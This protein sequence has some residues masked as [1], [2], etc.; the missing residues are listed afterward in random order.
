MSDVRPRDREWV[1]DDQGVAH[2][3][4]ESEGDCHSTVCGRFLRGTS[5]ILLPSSW[6]VP[7]CSACLNRMDRRVI[8]NRYSAVPRA[9][10]MGR[11]V[12]AE[13]GRHRKGRRRGGEH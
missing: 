2:M 9:V 12:Q 7:R 6:T 1:R 3:A 8:E 11:G 10:L 4:R 13:L 5:E